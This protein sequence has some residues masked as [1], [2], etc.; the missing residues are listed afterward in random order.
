MAIES[1]KFGEVYTF[2]AKGDSPPYIK[3]INEKKYVALSNTKNPKYSFGDGEFYSIN[4]IEG[5]YQNLNGNFSLG[6]EIKTI[7]IF[8]DDEDELNKKEY[9]RSYKRTLPRTNIFETGTIL[10]NDDQWVYENTIN[11]KV[12]EYPLKN[13][14]KKIPNSIAE[15]LNEY[16]QSENH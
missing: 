16:K 10:E 14:S 13:M 2:T 4:F 11:G 3:F 5:E 1:I 12:V 6:K 15:F 7:A 8:F 9:S